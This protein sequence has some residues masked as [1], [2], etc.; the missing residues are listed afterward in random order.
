MAESI[1]ILLGNSK[2]QKLTDLDCVKNDIVEMEKLIRATKKFNNIYTYLDRPI[3]S[4]KDELKALAKSED[5]TTELFFYFSGHGLS[6][7]DSFYMC[8]SEFNE[9]S[10]N[11]SGLSRDE[12]YDILREFNPS[13]T[14]VVIDACA[15]GANLIKNGTDFLRSA[16]KGKFN[17]FLQIASCLNDQTSRA[18]DVLSRFTDAFIE[19]AL[20]KE[21]GVVYYSDIKNGLKDAFKTLEDQTPHF[22]SQGTELAEFCS[23]AEALLTLREAFFAVEDKDGNSLPEEVEPIRAALIEIKRIESEVPAPMDAQVF[24]DDIFKAAFED[25]DNL[26]ELSE[27]F[28][29]RFIKYDDFTHVDNKEAIYNLI[30]QRPG[31]DALVEA[32]RWETNPKS[33]GTVF[34]Q[35]ITSSMFREPTEYSYA[36]ANCSGLSSVHVGIYFEPKLK[37]L[38]RVFSEIVFIPRLTEC[39]ILTSNSI[40][41]RS[42]WDSFKPSSSRKEW[43]WSPHKW[44]ESPSD[45]ADSKVKDPYDF[46]RSYVLKFGGKKD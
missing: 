18:G 21:R 16:P 6:D 4:V 15:S 22:V 7:Q 25:E 44:G 11:R 17:D 12:A 9:N 2:Y 34:D 13:Q 32:R 5:D 8:F 14:I 10:P 33:R 28:D 29:Q 38:N 36:I 20:T 1:A 24:I 3:S 19:A 46:L 26:G 45:V 40:E 41:L 35:L 23:D 42:G 27:L 39:L 31:N 30:Q 37:S 43:E